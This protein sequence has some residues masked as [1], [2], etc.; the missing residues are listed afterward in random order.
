MKTIF[1]I[2]A[3]VYMLGFTVL[4]IFDK[5]PNTDGLMLAIVLMLM[6]IFLS[7]EEKKTENAGV[8]TR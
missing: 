8:K 5:H 3:M 4:S 6:A 2:A 1:F 7:L